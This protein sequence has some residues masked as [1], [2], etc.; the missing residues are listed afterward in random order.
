MNYSRREFIN[1]SAGAGLALMVPNPFKNLLDMLNYAAASERPNINPYRDAE[2]EYK[3]NVEIAKLGFGLPFSFEQNNALITIEELKENGQTE[4][5]IIRGEANVDLDKTI[6][7]VVKKF[8][9]RKYI[10][11]L[12]ETVVDR[13]GMPRELFMAYWKPKGMPN[14]NSSSEQKNFGS[15][16]EPAE[17]YPQDIKKFLGLSGVSD[18]DRHIALE[19]GIP[20]DEISNISHVY[21]WLFHDGIAENPEF[22]WEGKNIRFKCEAGTHTLLSAFLYV[23]NN[24]ESFSKGNEEKVSIFHEGRVYDVPVKVERKSSKY[25]VMVEGISDIIGKDVK[26]ISFDVPAHGWPDNV[27][28]DLGG[29]L[30]AFVNAKGK[31]RFYK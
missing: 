10:H 16:L 31:L 13:D 1:T 18:Y 7:L 17:G 12:Y 29:L 24:L 23:L 26:M 8:R 22:K 9:V 28:A 6:N 25:R 3:V 15:Y 27:K 14:M 4:G 19:K 2:L 20:P 5:Y 11:I 30:G 21:H